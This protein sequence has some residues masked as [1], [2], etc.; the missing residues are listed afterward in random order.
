MKKILVS[1]VFPL[2]LVG[3]GKAQSLSQQDL[4][5]LKKKWAEREKLVKNL[6][7]QLDKRRFEYHKTYFPDWQSFEESTDDFYFYNRKMMKKKSNL[8]EIWIKQVA[9]SSKKLEMQEEGFPKEQVYDYSIML[10]IVDC[11]NEKIK[12]VQFNNYD[13][14]ENV[15]SSLTDNGVSEWRRIIPDSIGEAFMNIACKKK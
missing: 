4:D 1:L 12:L 7:E 13:E 8:V 5:D 14:K 6:G 15:I 3:L 11:K 10:Q 9:K 2:L